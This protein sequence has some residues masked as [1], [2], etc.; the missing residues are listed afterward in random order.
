MTDT[1]ARHNFGR[2]SDQMSGP[3]NGP[4]RKTEAAPNLLNQIVFQTVEL[5][6]GTA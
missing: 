1:T 2:V 6:S 5:N 3:A 4:A